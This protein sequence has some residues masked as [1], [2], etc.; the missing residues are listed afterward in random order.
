MQENKENP[1]SSLLRPVAGEIG[2][3]RVNAE[4]AHGLYFAQDHAQKYMFAF[5][6][7]KPP[8]TQE[9][10]PLNGI[11]IFH[12]QVHKSPA[13][14]LS[15]KDNKDW[16][17]FLKICLDLYDITEQEKTE[18]K[19]VDAFY[20]RLRYW[21]YFLKR[22]TED[23]LS[24]EEQLGLIGEL[25]ILEKYVLSNHKALDAVN[26]WTGAEDDVQDFSIGKNRIE[27]KASA[28]PSKNE[29]FISS[30]EQLYNK[31]C[32]IYLTVVYLGQAA[33]DAENA[34][35]LFSLAERIAGYVK[36]Q[37]VSAYEAF[38]QKLSMRG[39]FLDGSYND[40]FYLPS[41]VK[42]YSIRDEFPRITPPDVR[43]G[44]SKAKYSI[45]LTFCADYE[46]PIDA[47]FKKD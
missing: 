41:S 11:S 2:S 7:T 44:I 24:K 18:K 29:V 28:S 32:P 35:S 4:S 19:A 36:E 21:Q 14:V 30:L 8:A 15:L 31:E 5:T 40:S 38:I 10:V 37:N 39:L 22:N 33:A 3:R 16:P 17:I 26:F 13:I 25:L 12:T 45:N 20:N 42:A 47:V 46:V 43:H 1:W 23:T 6:L 34:I 27:V 9:G